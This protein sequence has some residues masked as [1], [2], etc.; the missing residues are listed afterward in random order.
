MVRESL[1]IYVEQHCQK[2]TRKSRKVF[3]ILGSSS[4]R[5]S[6]LQNEV[7][8]LCLDGKDSL[9]GLN[10]VLKSTADLNTQL[11]LL[12]QNVGQQLGKALVK[13]RGQIKRQFT[14]TG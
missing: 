6:A 9:V 14:V 13:G 5:D 11:S 4:L 10:Q 1:T 8:L 12:V 2:I 3:N 7:V